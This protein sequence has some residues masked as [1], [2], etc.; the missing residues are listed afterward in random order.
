M[1][2]SIAIIDSVYLFQC[3]EQQYDSIFPEKN[4]QY[5][6]FFTR[7]VAALI[8]GIILFVVVITVTF[9]FSGSLF[10]NTFTVILYYAINIAYYAGLESSSKQATLGKRVM[11]IKVTNTEGGRISFGQGVGRFFG[12]Y[13]SGLI[14]CIG[15]L[16][17]IWDKK[18]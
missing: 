13:L 11:D 4:V 1:L 14:L 8:D 12:K 15:Y 16:M 5:A 2:R 7:F 3:M 6:G 18:K 10:G 17:I 9:L